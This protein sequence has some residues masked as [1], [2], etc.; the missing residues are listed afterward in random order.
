MDRPMT[1]MPQAPAARANP[2]SQFFR[3]VKMYISLPSGSAYYG[4]GVV[5]LTASGEV[6]VMAMTGKDEIALKNP[7]GLLNGEA[8]IEVI[9]SCVPNVIN[10]RALLA[11]DIDAIITAIRYATYNDTL[12][13]ELICPNCKAEN[14]FKVDMQQAL[15]HMEFL[16]PEYIVDLESGLSVF[17]KPYAFPEILKGLHI[18]LENAKIGRAIDSQQL[19]DEQRSAMF[20][21]A[22]KEIATT[23]FELLTTAIVKIQKE[24]DGLEVTD[25]KFIK[26]FLVNI[27]KKDVDKIHDLIE[28]INQIGIKRTFQAKCSACEHEWESDIDFN[29]VNFS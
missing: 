23:K 22:F 14:T 3:S 6:G 27:D 19:T 7:D 4:P 12:E 8:L 2:L 25:K 18:Q 1:Q 16:D 29:P 10:P 15:D 13:T 28:K 9:T 5:N 21:K 24:S 17:V 20:G 11:N 26:E